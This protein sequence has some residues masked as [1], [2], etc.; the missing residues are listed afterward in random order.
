MGDERRGG[1]VDRG[2]IGRALWAWRDFEFYSE[3][4]GNQSGGCTEEGCVGTNGW[5]TREEVGTPVRSHLGR[6]GKRWQWLIEYT[7][8][9]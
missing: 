7:S 6:R 8:E 1:E 4:D 5:G 3:H 2:C 9:T